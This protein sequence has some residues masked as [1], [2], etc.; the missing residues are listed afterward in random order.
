MCTPPPAAPKE[1]LTAKRKSGKQTRLAKLAD[2][3]A[4]SIFPLVRL[5][6]PARENQGPSPASRCRLYSQHAQMA[7]PRRRRR[8]SSRLCTTSCSQ[9]AKNSSIRPLGRGGAPLRPTKNRP[10]LRAAL[11]LP[12]RRKGRCWATARRGAAAAIHCR[13]AA[14]VPPRLT[15]VDASGE[16]SISRQLCSHGTSHLNATPGPP[17]LPLAA[18]SR[19]PQR[20]PQALLAQPRHARGEQRRSLDRSGSLPTPLLQ[21]CRR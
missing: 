18:R 6:A 16:L 11:P 14:V 12:R 20:V 21:A 13:R 9:R 1:S 5:P 3:A 7:N 10:V 15:R 2:D 4:S 8:P 17:A 19:A